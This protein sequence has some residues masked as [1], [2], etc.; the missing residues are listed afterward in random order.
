MFLVTA[1]TACGVSER[2]KT[3]RPAD[4]AVEW[5][6]ESVFEEAIEPEPGSQAHVDPSGRDYSFAAGG[7]V[8]VPEVFPHDIP[9]YPGASIRMA[10][11]LDIRDV[12]VILGTTDSP[13]EI[14]AFY[15]RRLYEQGWMFTGKAGLEGQTYLGYMKGKAELVVVVSPEKGGNIVSI[16]YKT[17]D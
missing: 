3:S 16:A 4:E 5:E 6:T 2:E 1:A 9:L 14:E 13:S 7:K 15:R 17:R 11:K 10:Q 12:N 8:T